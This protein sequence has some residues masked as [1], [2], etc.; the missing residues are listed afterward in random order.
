MTGQISRSE[1]AQRIWAGT[2]E[3]VEPSKT[4]FNDN[5]ELVRYFFE[6][7]WNKG[8]L[9]VVDG[10]IAANSV[11][12]NRQPG[13]PRGRNGYKA[14][15]TMFRSAFPDIRYNLEQVFTDADRV[16]IRFSGT[17]THLGAFMGIPQTGK[18]ITFSGMTF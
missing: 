8:N 7:V 3:T 12:H 2:Q 16:A 4:N 1:R 15:V 11:D 13:A 6:E 9:A 17:G 10:L 14:S 5:A 18:Q